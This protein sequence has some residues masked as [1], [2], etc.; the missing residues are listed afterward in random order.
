MRTLLASFGFAFSVAVANADVKLLASW[1][2]RAQKIDE[3]AAL[4]QGESGDTYLVDRDSG[5][6]WHWRAGSATSIKLAG[7][8]APVPDEDISGVTRLSN[9]SWV[10]SNDGDDAAYVFSESDKKTRAIGAEDALND[11]AAVVASASQ[12]LYFADRGNDRIAIY[13]P[14][15]NFLYALGNDP[16]DTQH[17]LSAPFAV[18][19]DGKEQIYVLDRKGRLSIYG[20]DGRLIEQWEEG[21]WS[22]LKG[23]PAKLG[24]IAVAQNGQI[25]VADN[26]NQKIIHYDWRTKKVLDSFGSKGKGPGQ[27][28]DVSA[29]QI[30]PS[31]QLTVL[32]RGNKKIEWYQLANLATTIAP[33]RLPLVQ[34]LPA[35][36]NT[37]AQVQMNFNNDVF[38]FDA[39][40]KKITKTDAAG[41]TSDI[42][43][44]LTK[45]EH[46]SVSGDYL[47]VFESGALRV[48]DA[49]VKLL[50]SMARK[51][52]GEGAIDSPMAAVVSQGRLFV[53][54]TDNDRLQAFT[55]EGIF[56]GR[57]NDGKT[58]F[59]SPHAIVADSK[60][61]LF[62]ADNQQKVIVAL[63]RDLEKQFQIGNENGALQD[64]I[65]LAMDV[66]DKLYA[67]VKQNNSYSIRVY[68]GRNLVLRFGREGDA[69]Q[70][71]NK[72][73]G[74]VVSAGAK[75]T[76]LVRDE[77]RQTLLAYGVVSIPGAVAGVKI[78]GNTQ[79]TR[80]RWQMA[81]ERFV[82]QYRVYG[83]NGDGQ[84]KQLLAEVNATDVVIGNDKNNY[85]WFAVSAKSG[86][87]AESDLSQAWR[88]EFGIGLRA[89]KAQNYGEAEQAFARSVQESPDNADAL[90]MLGSS[91]LKQNKLDA[92]LQQFDL[93]ATLPDQRLVA[94]R[95]KLE[96][97]INAKRYLDARG[98]L[99]VVL[100]A[101][102][103]EI[104]PYWW[105]AEI[106][107]Q[108]NDPIGAIGCLEEVVKRDA[109]HNEALLL[110]AKT[111]I[112]AGAID[113]G[114]QYFD[115][116]QQNAP[117][118]RRIGLLRAQQLL[119]IGRFQEALPLFQSIDS[120]PI[121]QK[122][123]QLGLA[124]CQLALNDLAQAKSIALALAADESVGDEATL[125]LGKVAL[126]QNQP[127]E[128]LIAYSR[129]LRG[130]KKS[131]QTWMGMAD[132]Y[133]ALLQPEKELEALTS[134]T[135][136]FDATSMTWLRLGQKQLQAKNGSAALMAMQNALRLAPR[137]LA[138]LTDLARTELFVGQLSEA[139]DHAK[140]ALSQKQDDAE[141]W[142][143]N[144]TVAARQGKLIEAIE[145][146]K[147]AQALA[148]D[149]LDIQLQLANL[150][151][152]AGQY[153]LAEPTLAKIEAVRKDWAATFVL[154]AKLFAAAMV[155]DKA[156]TAA[157]KA[158]ALEG[159]DENKELLNA[160]LAGRKQGQ[161]SKL[162]SA[163]LTLESLKLT[164]IFSAA[165]KN[166]AKES[167][168]S[169][170]VRNTGAAEQNNLRLRFEIK[171]FMDFPY[172]F[173]VS[174]LAANSSVEVPLYATFNNRILQ[175][176]EDTGVQVEV[177]VSFIQNANQTLQSLT[178]PT[179]LY[180]KNAILWSAFDRVGAFVTPRDDVLRDFVRQT[181]NAHLPSAKS[182]NKNVL[183]AMTYFSALTAQGLR[184]QPDPNTPYAKLA[185]DQI[186]YVQFPRE[187]LRLKSGDCDDLSILMAAGLENLGVATALVDVPGHLFLLFDSGVAF[188]ERDTISLDP[189]LVVELGG[190]AWIPLEA[191]M[192][193]TSFAE[194]WA[195][196]ARKYRLHHDA[197]RAQVAML[198]TAWQTTAPVTLPA[199]DAISTPDVS[200]LAALV[201]PQ[202]ELLVGKS[203]ERLTEPF[204]VMMQLGADNALMQLQIAIQYA[205]AGLLD[206]SVTQL[207]DLLRQSPQYVAAH[208]AMGNVYYLKRNY[209][210]ALDSYL[211]AERLA[212]DDAGIKINVAL[213]LYGLQQM[214][215]ASAKFRESLV[216]DNTLIT[217]YETLAKVLSN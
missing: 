37:C 61:T 117:D 139:R 29:L 99:D 122:Q 15:G 137:G 205:K 133:A 166:Y 118:D 31:G 111:Y 71:M 77:K 94:T 17:K 10:F 156:V 135:Q 174:K 114:L 101:K 140:Q 93:L 87:G 2:L 32:D 158:V 141:L 190:Q 97:L 73:T 40:Q 215:D 46:F 209:R 134:A 48:Y 106:N 195:E 187:T 104:E 3:P 21:K 79:G 126:A 8:G 180:G 145:Y 54:D 216:L 197:N 108:L 102:P 115:R 198:R 110:L 67:L 154:R 83:W 159:S 186:D 143:L 210:R 5:L 43:G 173:D 179:T 98:V 86:F 78:V 18:A 70:D 206:K 119:M 65:G 112:G 89:F 182:V 80:L 66:D 202:T 76:V 53:A 16:L 189:D 24:A 55:L 183:L 72:P 203:V 109:K 192:V 96:T 85:E 69:P 103:T 116:A 164:P 208:V 20:D 131:A 213:S 56:V 193:A 132:V 121:L 200:R 162:A 9:G 74:I 33:V 188:R 152:D 125:I 168:G 170:V 217:R 157:Q 92:A 34:N 129:L 75:P 95:L 204:R 146:T 11:P 7:K 38:C 171:G 63:N 181:V 113:Q 45:V 123:G 25:F 124:Q 165:Y 68:Q 136:S 19:V 41:K 90:Q 172:S 81:P 105:C 176:D 120:D 22:P 28:D 177:A 23:K 59:K 128:A 167:I 207:E 51:G 155:F 1:D 49:S 64:I 12:R 199:G 100:A 194:S 160:L 4:A 47:I 169:V 163:S 91:L 142:L 58:A 42:L 107:V 26:D 13:S 148:A 161:E 175:V 39:K 84:N 184:Y 62:A 153:E 201:Q 130:E 212:N 147:R 150:Y 191:T 44:G 211:V 36:K 214:A 30:V 178:R 52:S 88:D 82:A 196:G 27:F 151:Y 144:A 127:Q 149:R 138:V 14:D 6:W 50:L 60:G 185:G 35:Q 57:T